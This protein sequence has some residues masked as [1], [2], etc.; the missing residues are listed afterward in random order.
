VILYVVLNCDR[1]C[2]VYVTLCSCMFLTVNDEHIYNRHV[3]KE[4]KNLVPL[5]VGSILHIIQNP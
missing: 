3:K 5:L 1:Y 2:L 4:E